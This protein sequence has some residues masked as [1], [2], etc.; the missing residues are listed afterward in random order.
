MLAHDVPTHSRLEDLDSTGYVVVR[1]F[2]NDAEIARFEADYAASSGVDT[3]YGVRQVSAGARSA[4][5]EK[6]AAMARAVAGASSV[7]VDIA[8]VCAFGSAYFTTEGEIGT[9][10]HQDAVSYFA[11]QNHHDYLNF[12]VPIV[13]PVRERSNLC[14]IPLDAFAARSPELAARLRGRGATRFVVKDGATTVHDN[15]TGGIHGVLPYA[16]DEL[17]V[18][19]QLGRGDLLLLRGDVIHR[20]EDKD[21]HRVAVSIRMMNRETRVRRAELVRGGLLKAVVMTHGR[22]DFRRLFDCFD[23]AGKDELTIGEIASFEASARPARA[24]SFV[25]F[26]AFLMWNR[27]RERLGLF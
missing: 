4:I 16:L 17:A 1:S 13:K 24:T 21:T 7:R 8:S 5:D 20:T 9:A 10:W 3:S 12:Y 23:A 27:M 19:P 6:L 2:L 26:M 25:S 11:Y 18:T 22:R 14:V 15:N